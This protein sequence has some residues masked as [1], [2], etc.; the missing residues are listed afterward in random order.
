MLYIKAL[1][2][3]DGGK[4]TFKCSCKNEADFQSQRQSNT[5]ISMYMSCNQLPTTE[6]R[7]ILKKADFINDGT[8][9]G[10]NWIGT[11]D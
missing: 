9:S 10:L 7:Y 3:V 8:E 2:A 6:Y 1:V 11:N 4:Q 5:S